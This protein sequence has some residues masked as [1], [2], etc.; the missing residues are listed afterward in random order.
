M[1]M[2]FSIQLKFTVFGSSFDPNEITELCKIQPHRIWKAGDT[3]ASTIMKRK[4]YGWTII[5][6]EIESDGLDLLLKEMIK[7]IT[8]VKSLLRDHI[9]KH[10]L[11]SEL[12]C[13]I[14]LHEEAPSINIDQKSVHF[15]S[16][17]GSSIDIDIYLGE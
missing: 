16:D 10:N 15:F 12:A 11:N 3:I 6:K 5:S 7:K 2:K 17:L 14:T 8:P 4:N 1:N 9:N 13:I